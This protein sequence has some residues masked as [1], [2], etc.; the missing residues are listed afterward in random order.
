[1]DGSINGVDFNTWNIHRFQSNTAWGRA[2]FN[3]DMVTDVRDFNL[4]NA[5]KFLD[6]PVL[7]TSS[8]LR[9]PRA[10]LRGETTTETETAIAALPLELIGNLISARSFIGKVTEKAG[11]SA[12][13][14][15]L[16]PAF[17]RLLALVKGDKVHR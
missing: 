12:A 13:M 16:G 17:R 10:A 1:M 14:A 4:W 2:D 8:S 3:G 6:E 15:A 9:T 7:T 5:N 11:P